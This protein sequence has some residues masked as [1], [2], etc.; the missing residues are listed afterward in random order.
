MR[1]ESRIGQGG[2]N[3]PGRE[4]RVLKPT[5]SQWMWKRPDAKGNTENAKDVQQKSVF[6]VLLIQ[7]V[8]PDLSSREEQ[9]LAA[10]GKVW[11]NHSWICKS[12]GSRWACSH[13]I[14]LLLVPFPLWESI[15]TSKETG[16]ILAKSSRTWLSIAGSAGKGVVAT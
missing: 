8:M 7:D 11:P 2:K 9:S 14:E 5:A 3:W 15:S 13:P 4:I 10:F 16:K 6:L 12:G 1:T